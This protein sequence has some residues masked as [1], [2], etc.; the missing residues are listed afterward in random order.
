[1][2]ESEEFI[3]YNALCTVPGLTVIATAACECCGR[4]VRI[5]ANKTGGGYYMCTHADDQGI[6]CNHQQRWGQRVSFM[7]RKA[8]REAGNKPKRVRLP[9]LI[10]GKPPPV[11]SNQNRPIAANDNQEPENGPVQAKGGLFG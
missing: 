7:L 9:L 11:A 5:K 8:Y 6:G 3:N 2:S 10:G 4:T 1:M